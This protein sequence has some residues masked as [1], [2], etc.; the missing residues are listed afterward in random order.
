MKKTLF[1]ALLFLAQI[2]IG[3][4]R[5]LSDSAKISLITCSPGEEL[6][7]AFGHTGIRVTDYINDFDVVFNYGTFDFEQP[8][9]YTNFIRGRMLYSLAVDRFDN[10]RQQYVY[11]GR[12][13]EEQ[14]LNLTP[15]DKKKIFAALFE[16]AKEENRNYRYDF[17][18]DNCCTRPRDVL[19]KSLG[20][21]LT[22]DYSILDSNMT[23]R[24]ALKPWVA[25]KPWVD[26]GF[27][28]I[29]GLPCEVTAT[30][31]NQTFLPSALHT[32]IKGATIDGQPFV[33]T[34]KVIVDLPFSP[35]KFEGIHPL[36]VTI[37][38][39]VF[40]LL[41]IFVER[42]KKTHFWWFDFTL[43]FITGLLGTFFLGMWLFTEHYS[44]PKNLNML[45]LLPTHLVASFYL[46]RNNKPKWL[47]AYFV[48]TFITL[49]ILLA[50]W[51]KLPQ[52]F[53][54]AVLPMIVLMAN[55]A[56][57]IFLYFK[58]QQISDRK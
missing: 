5:T 27:D 29:L 54:I 18:W 33:Q 58:L 17:F 50:S 51:G 23:M 14:V 2:T 31:R 40:G 38:I 26:F 4:D 43:F 16:N 35:K 53:N 8:G 49:I 39:M 34:D 28:L 10:F 44:V 13:V 19:E 52:P 37:G 11:E 15:T 36:L 48:I 24:Q 57:R 1:I 7:S 30:P 21:R 25:N 9:F 46:L 3:Q 45:W 12:R 22:Y 55:R 42:M 56:L 32:L 47:S 6:Y 20:N 41:L